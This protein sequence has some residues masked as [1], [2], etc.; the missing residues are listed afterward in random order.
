MQPESSVRVQNIKSSRLNIARRMDQAM[1]GGGKQTRRRKSKEVRV[2]RDGTK[3]QENTW[4]KGPGSMGMR[5]WGRQA[6]ELFGLFGH[7]VG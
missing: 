4:P 5:S 6:Q 1:V 7:R 2:P 3:S